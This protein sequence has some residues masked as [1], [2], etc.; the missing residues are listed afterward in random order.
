MATILRI[1]R[2]ET[3]GNPAILAAGELAY[4]GL[5][6]NGSNGGDRLYIGMGVET[7]GDAA[8][9]LVIGGKY[10]T[11]MLDHARGTLTASSAIL[12]D[13]NKK[14]D[15]FYVDDIQL[16]G[17]EITTT[18]AD[19]D[20]RISANGT[21]KVHVTKNLEVDGDLQID[22][23]DITLTG[24]PTSILLRDNE[25]SAL[26][27]KE[28][29]NPY[30]TIKT[31]DTAESITLHKLTSIISDD[32]TANAVVGVLR[33]EHQT[34]GTPVN[35]IGTGIELSTE[36]SG[37]NVEV[38]VALDSVATETNATQETFD[39]VIR[40]MT[41]GA[42]AAQALKINNNT[43]QIGS[44]ATATTLTTLGTSDLTIN[45]NNGTNS[46]SIKI[47]HGT[48]GNIEI[49]PNGSGD[50]HINADL[51]RV[52]D[53]NNDVAITTNGTG[54]ITLSTNG[55]TDSG[56]IDIHDGVNGNIELSVNGTGNIYANA[57]LLRVGTNNT[58]ATI[59][60]Q[61]TGDVTIN[62]NSGTN[63]GF[64]KINNGSNS[65]IEIEP[66]GTG[67]VFLTTDT[68][69]IGDQNATATITTYGTG[70]LVLNTNTG[71]DTGSITIANGLNG[72]ITVEPNGTGDVRVNSDTLRVGDA[73]TATTI[74]TNGTGDLTLSTNEG[75]NS[76]TI[77]IANGSNGNITV[78]PNGTGKVYLDTDTV[79]IGDLDLA[80]TITT[81]G[82]GNLTLSTNSGTNSGSIVIA[83]GADGNITIETN[84]TGDVLVNADTLRIG[85]NN[86]TAT[87]T[88][89]G[90]GD[91][92]L[93]TNTGTNSGTFTISNGVDGNIALQPNGNGRVRFYNA[94][95]FPGA[96]GA[97]G[98][99]LTTNGSGVISWQ[100]ASST[101]SINADNATPESISLLT[102]T[103]LFTGGEG[104][105]TATSS[106]TVTISMEL[107]T[108]GANVGASNIGGAAFSNANFDVT[109]GFV[110]LKSSSVSNS[111]LANSSL[112]IGSTSISLGGTST[113]LAGLTQVDIDN[114]RFDGNTISSTNSNGNIT[115]D[116]NGTGV[117][118]VS[119]TRITNLSEPQNDSDAATKYYVDA[120]RSGLDVKQSVRVATTV[121]LIALYDN[122]GA[123]VGGTLTNNDTQAALEIDGVSLS[124][125]NRVLVKDQAGGDAVQ[126]GI[127]TVTTVGDGSTNWVLTRATDA[128]NLN[129]TGEVT[130]GM[131]VFVEAGTVNSDSGFVLTTNDPITLG[132]TS[133][134][135]TVFSTSG[136]LVAGAGLSKDGYTLKVNVDADG[137]IEINSDNLRLKST[138]AGNGLTYATGVIAVGGTSDRISVTGDAVDISSS[139]IG[140]SSI[141]TLG[142][143][144]TGV[145]QGT[146]V[147]AAY[148]GTGQTTYGVGDILYASA[149]TTLTKR[150][151][152]TEGQVLRVTLVGSD[153]IPTWSHL[154]GGAY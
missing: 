10:F 106:N 139:Y 100:S 61:G 71:T 69:R 96:D 1:K 17:N 112:T 104:I 79:R 58:A 56:T 5:A 55:G 133:L 141:T 33:V 77:A 11:D 43:L 121:P 124:V 93:S 105:D 145:W 60:T 14:V 91:L 86:A 67:D 75:N 144:A 31:A 89:R 20:L 149:A 80:A 53:A 82:T 59:T 110:T 83:N 118:D 3:A 128:D 76:G 127:Y 125:G 12:V 138:V 26:V 140:Q 27:F 6:D 146:S 24:A 137:G 123:V 116:P 45:T 81:N 99:V 113:V 57:N 23:G 32:A 36:T 143:I 64:I 90:T 117:I 46:G 25:N 19:T 39:F 74:T 4:S 9:H 136:T 84:G 15:D 73:N 2:S 35:G 151:I 119:N 102:E 126:N 7:D 107:A 97:A 98:Q 42:A 95:N 94:Y 28:G 68:V 72:H 78:A 111:Q 18:T 129:P 131:F 13:S 48:N 87:I 65:N 88:T 130:S 153:L 63:S 103:L 41:A 66:N 85:D 47:N 52:G 150:T 70:D 8:N 44:N 135:F 29:N 62:T 38:G 34:T 21:G 147:A 132:S 101:L 148:G 152:G 50:V 142:T 54:K 154:D 115:L 49:E 109:S 16:N 40:T 37:N 30:L 122:G 51:I 120:A 22:G 92:V 114:L 108:A 134:S